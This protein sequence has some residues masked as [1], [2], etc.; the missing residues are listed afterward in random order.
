MSQSYAAA[1]KPHHWG[2]LSEPAA[3]AQGSGPRVRRGYSEAPAENKLGL[4]DS[5][6]M[7]VT[8]VV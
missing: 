1:L 2:Q 7:I 8:T 3:V 6:Q 4:A 5:S